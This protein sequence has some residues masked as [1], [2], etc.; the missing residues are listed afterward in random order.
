M[1]AR[2]LPLAAARAKRFARRVVSSSPSSSVNLGE[3]KLESG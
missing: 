3:L 2:P 1:E